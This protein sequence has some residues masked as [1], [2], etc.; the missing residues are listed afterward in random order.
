MRV[1]DINRLGRR[2][3]SRENL[4]VPS[5][6]EGILRRMAGWLSESDVTAYARMQFEEMSDFERA[7]IQTAL[8]KYCELD[9]LAMVMI[10][11]GWV[12]MLKQQMTRSS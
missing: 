11:E 3:R 2:N 12:D 10:Y 6:I 1:E 7:E 8:L 5:I 9:T 4:E